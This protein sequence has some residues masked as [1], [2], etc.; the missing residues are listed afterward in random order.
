MPHHPGQLPTLHHHFASALPEMSVAYTPRSAEGAELGV[1][2]E[3]LA[4]DLGLDPDWLRTPDGLGFLTGTRLHPAAQPVAQGYSGHQFGGFSPRLGDGRA[5]LLGELHTPAGQTVDI[6]LKGSGPTP[7]SR[8]G[9]GYAA[10]GPMLREYLVSE[11]MHALGV[12]TTRALAVIRTGAQIVRPNTTDPD[13]A[14]VFEHQQGAILVRV[15]GSH[16]RVGSVQYARLLQT[17]QNTG[18]LAR[19]LGVAR[20]RHY[21]HL[22]QGDY[23]GL[24]RAVCQGQAELVAQWMR[25]G[26]V[27]GVL[28][29]DNTT[30][31]GETIDYGPCAFLDRL[32]P[33]TWFSSVDTHGRYAYRNQPSIIMW[34]LAR[35]A[36]AMLPLVDVE[37]I[38]AEL[39][40][41]PAVYRRA[42][43]AHMGR[44]LGLSAHLQADPATR[45]VATALIDELPGTLHAAELDMHHFYRDLAYRDLAAGTVEAPT[46]QLRDWIARW[47][48]LRPDR[49]AMAEVNPLII[50]RNHVLNAALGNAEAGDMGPYLR[51]L[52]AVTHPFRDS[53][54]VRELDRPAHPD[55]AKTTTY[56]GT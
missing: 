13:K 29:T 40:G 31:S 1:F 16:L 5:V 17:E 49:A 30:L 36:E 10:L 11:A 24:Y 50:P 34:N 9:D 47:G 22:P 21:P 45:D 4:E 41:F 39:E 52:D 19:L 2:N 53:A 42:W 3:K 51:L 38:G 33:D 28:N 12:P 23:L 20:E 56:C 32:D 46:P 44:T 35:L 43:L 37:A 25:L 26:F 6:H 54:D 7:F 18:P 8:G 48:D 27:H 15:A 14:G 55:A